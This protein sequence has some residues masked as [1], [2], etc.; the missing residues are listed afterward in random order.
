MNPY[1]GTSSKGIL[2]T[3]IPY[4]LLS[5]SDVAPIWQTVAAIVGAYILIVTAYSITLEAIHRK[6]R[7]KHEREDENDWPS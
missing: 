6:R 1:L 3:G 2:G 5:W 4:A 7:D